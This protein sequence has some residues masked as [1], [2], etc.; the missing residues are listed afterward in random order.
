M[1]LKEMTGGDGTL[2]R[3]DEMSFAACIQSCLLRE[4]E[5]FMKVTKF[6]IHLLH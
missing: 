5:P 4:S 6:G 1:R 3:Q 2:H